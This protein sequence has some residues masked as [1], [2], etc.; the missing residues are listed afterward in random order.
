MNKIQIGL[1]TVLLFLPLIPAAANILL[2]YLIIS[3]A[4]LAILLYLF[5]YYKPWKDLK[6]ATITLYF[7][8][9]YTL[10]IAL[11]VFLVLPLRPR[12]IALV[13]LIETIPLIFNVTIILKSFLKKFISYSIF[14]INEGYLLFVLILI[15][16]AIVGRFFANFYELIVIYT[17]S[18]IIGILVL[19]YFR[20]G[21]KK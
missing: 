6:A 17:T 18:L 14:K 12:D 2:P 21:A 11:G 9:V 10:S 8:M 13:G 15:L 19:I 5:Y 16:G 7:S 20:Q 4:Y 1:L 3:L